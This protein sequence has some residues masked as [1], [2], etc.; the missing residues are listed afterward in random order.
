MTSV[1]S[2]SIGHTLRQVRL[3]K[4]KSLRQIASKAHISLAHYSD[5][6]RGLKQASDE[7]LESIC[8]GLDYELADLFDE[9]TQQLRK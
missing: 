9:V 2:R 4:S 8:K 3:G 7:M 6:E 5:V 1:I